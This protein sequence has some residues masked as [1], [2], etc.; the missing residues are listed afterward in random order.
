MLKRPKDSRAKLAG[1]VLA[2]IS[3]GFAV[4]AQA[5]APVAQVGA[6]RSSIDDAEQAI[7][8]FLSANRGSNGGG[9][10]SL[11]LG[12]SL[13]GTADADLLVGALGV[14]VLFGREGDDI[15]IGGTEDFNPLNRDRAF[16]DSG[17]DVFIWACLAGRDVQSMWEGR[18]VTGNLARSKGRS[19]ARSCVESAIQRCSY[20]TTI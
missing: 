17:D 10:Q 4:A 6:D 8:D 14:D 19:M 20:C 2:T 18:I 1:G 15:L 3:L 7:Q 5:Q 13:T 11:Q 16:G 12:D 9:D